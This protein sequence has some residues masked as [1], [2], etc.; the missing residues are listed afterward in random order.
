[1]LTCCFS[2]NAYIGGAAKTRT[3]QNRRH[4]LPIQT[5]KFITIPSAAVG[6]FTHHW[7]QTQIKDPVM[8]VEK[9]AYGHGNR[10]TLTTSDR[11][12]AVQE[13]PLQALH[14]LYL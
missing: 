14:T 9:L 11:D 3:K 5:L 8:L 1:M 13:K 4:D 2:D 6:D 7:L 12:Y 10:I